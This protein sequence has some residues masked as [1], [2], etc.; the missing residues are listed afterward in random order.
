MDCYVTPYKKLYTDNNNF[1]LY[2]R[3]FV[4]EGKGEGKKLHVITRNKAK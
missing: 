2:P 1:G 3:P 4:G